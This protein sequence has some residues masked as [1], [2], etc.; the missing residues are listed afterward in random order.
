MRHPQ[1]RVRRIGDQPSQPI[2]GI[3]GKGVGANQV[4]PPLRDLGLRLHQI[5]RR[6][7]TGLDANLVLPGELLCELER[8]LLNGDV[9]QSRLERPVRL[10]D[11]GHRLNDRLAEAKL[12][13][14]VVSAGDDDLLSRNVDRAIPQQRLRERE[15]DP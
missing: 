14:L 3:P 2:L 5:E 9:R 12:G 10:L 8:S 13:A 4:L 7:L 1:R 11:R 6:N 15:L